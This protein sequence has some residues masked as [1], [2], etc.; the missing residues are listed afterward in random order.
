MKKIF[1]GFLAITIFVFAA[2]NNNNKQN[3]QQDHNMMNN[4][5]MNHDK[6]KVDSMKDMKHDSMTSM[7]HGNEDGSMALAYKN[8]GR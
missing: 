7:N 8:I 2:C 4:D 3:N 1:S 6:M 5:S